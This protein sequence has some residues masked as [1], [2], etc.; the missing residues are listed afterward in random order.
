MKNTRYILII[1]LVSFFV[2]HNF[3][4][5]NAAEKEMLSGNKYHQITQSIDEQW[6]LLHRARQFEEQR[7][8]PEARE[9]YEVLYEDWATSSIQGMAQVG[10]IRM[11]ENLGFYEQA[12]S[13]VEKML[14]ANRVP[15]TVQKYQQ[16]KQR[17]LQK[18]EAQKRGEKIEEAKLVPQSSGSINT[19]ADFETAS[20]GAQK[21]YMEEKLPRNTEI[22]RLSKQAMLAEHAGKFSEAKGYYEQLLSKKDDA[23]AAQGEVAWPML[24]CAVQRMSEL[25]GDET[26]EKEMLVW[27]K[28][29][30]LA[31]QGEYHKHLDGLL[32]NVQDHLRARLRY[33]NL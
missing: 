27:L 28:T 23:I 11:Y 26:R 29:N 2:M 12:L 4:V 22:Y 10:L 14:Q 25:T 33:F 15:E 13:L 24:H 17:L 32:P 9:I 8:F 19:I 16:T 1:G 7:K 30:M 20:Y 21:Q 6:S 5:C 18:I 31:L 3:I